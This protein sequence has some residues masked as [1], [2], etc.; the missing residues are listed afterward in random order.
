MKIASPKDQKQLAEA[1][2]LAYKEGF[3]QGQ[4][5]VGDFKDEKVEAAK[6]KVRAQLVEAKLAFAYAEP[7]NK[8][9]S[10]SGDECTVGKLLYLTYID[11]R[12]QTLT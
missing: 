2:E 10:R 7:E 3:Y 12:I 1:K 11:S 6:P 5:L 9:V 8:V 4:M